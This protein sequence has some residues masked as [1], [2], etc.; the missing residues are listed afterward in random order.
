M[1]NVEVNDKGHL[2]IGGADAVKLAEDYD[3][4]LYVIDEKRIREN[5]QRLHKAF[6]KYYPNFQILYACK[7]N[8]N[9][10][11]LRILEE[12]G[13]GIDAVSPGEIYMALLAGF[14][15]EKILY[16]GNNLRDD[17]ILFA[18]ESGVMINIDSKSQLIRLSKITDPENVKI[19]FRI[20]PMV[21]AGHHEHCI[22]GGELSKFGIR[23]DEAIK[24]YKLAQELGFQPIGIHAHIGSGI[25]DPEPF[26][27]A[28]EKL[29]DIAGKVSKA[30]NIDFKFIDFGGGLGIPY[31]P[32]EKPL[33]IEEFAEKIT[34]LFMEKLD[35]YSLGKPTMY[36]EPGRYIVGDA[37]CLLTRVNTIKESYRKFAGVDAG[38]NTLV[39]PV[40][41]GSYHHIIVANRA[42]EKPVEK[43][44]IAGNLCESGDLFARD[45]KLPKLRE[46]DLLAILDAGAYAFSMSS[47]YNSRP[48]P[49][50]ILVKDG[51]AEIIRK[52]ED[53]SDLISKQVIP[54]RLLK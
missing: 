14:K 1:L 11:V 50:E 3:T 47:Q 36:L 15:P 27:L 52:R 5:Y 9:L 22:T 39:R 46:G 35:E 8:T 42:S 4:P 16:T 28:V 45:R 2:L 48:R 24:V 20:N 7:A 33:D 17:E 26:M 6:T 32:S 13:S 40:M 10:A 43:I 31:H 44:D 37:A 51:E 38:F 30:T 49:A 53:F 54:P 34:G 21:G 41:Y 19:S 18:T 12:E 23:E 29:M 25:L